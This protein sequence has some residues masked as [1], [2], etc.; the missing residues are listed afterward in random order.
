MTTASHILRTDA[1]AIGSPSFRTPLQLLAGFYF[2]FRFSLTYVAFQSDPRAGTVANLACSGLILVGACLYTLGDEQFSARRFFAGR[3]LWWLLA[4]LLASGSSLLWTGADSITAAAGYWAGMA[5]DVATV[6]L[7]VKQ[8][9]AK[10]HVDALMKGF[11]WGVLFVAA[12]AWLSPTLPDLR[13][14]NEEFLHPNGI[15]L[16]CGLAFFLAQYLAFEK[17]AW[18]WCCLALGITLLRSLSKTSIVA[19]VIAESFYLLRE[20]RISQ[21]V[22]IQIGFV[23]VIILAAFSTLLETYLTAYTTTDNA[24][25][26]TL[27]GRTLIWSTALGMGLE[28]PWIGH[29]LYSFRS[30][31]PTFWKFEPWHAHNEI[32]Q[33][34]FELGLLGV[35]VAV[36]LHLSLVVAARRSPSRLYGK[37]AIVL[38]LFAV[39][40][41]L[42]DTVIFGM[43]LPLWL[44][45]ALAIAL[46]QPRQEAI[47][48]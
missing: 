48:Q 34:F 24:N 7:L 15:G 45:A 41:G 14:G 13:I 30:L 22:K 29:G 40:H 46:M 47:A 23:V 37:L 16:H 3:T 39:I 27:T 9:N 26:E 28:R 42:S 35:I 17:P 6:L 44:F 10:E 11:I 19:F 32:L 25:A 18:K 5:M 2:A 20:K 43:S 21:W 31:I 12:I 33:Q 8:S 1:T 38:T 36:G 4:Y